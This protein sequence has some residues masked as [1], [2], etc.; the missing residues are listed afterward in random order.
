MSTLTVA[1]VTPPL[2]DSVPVAKVIG[3]F[4]NATLPVGV[5]PP[6]G[7]TVAVNTIAWPV[8]EGFAEEARVVVVLAVF[9]VWVSAVVVLLPVKFVSPA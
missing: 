5:P 1:V 9:T 7:V 3:P 6:L 4:L 8:T 2:V